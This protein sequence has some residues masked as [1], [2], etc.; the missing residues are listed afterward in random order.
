MGLGVDFWVLL[1]EL[2][3][4]WDAE[5]TVM[6]KPRYWNVWW[7]LTMA[8]AA[9]T[10]GAVVLEAFGVLRDLGVALGIAG[11]LL[12]VVFGLTAST[13]SSLTEFRGEVAPRLDRVT[14]LLDRII[15]L[16]DERLPRS[17]T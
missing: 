15:A 11:L 6:T 7:S 17:T 9:L 13:R 4:R 10:L 3:S 14:K 8:A 5:N 16:L 2:V 12:T 1:R